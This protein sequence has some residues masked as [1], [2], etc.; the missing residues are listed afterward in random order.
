MT[1]QIGK[2]DVKKDQVEI[3]AARQP[4]AFL[5]GADCR[6][7]VTM[8]SKTTVDGARYRRLVFNQKDSQ[9][10]KNRRAKGA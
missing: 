3:F 6:H 5:T 7:V 9:Q 2:T 10:S 1:I 4:D 8:T